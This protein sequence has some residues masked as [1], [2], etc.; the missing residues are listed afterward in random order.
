MLLFERSNIAFCSNK[1]IMS[2]LKINNVD[3]NFRVVGLTLS[4]FAISKRKKVNGLVIRGWMIKYI[5][6]AL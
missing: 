3:A 4:K 2:I 6:P 1:T 5:G